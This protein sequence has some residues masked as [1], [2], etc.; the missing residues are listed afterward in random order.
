MSLFTIAL[1]G[2]PNCGKT[3]LFNNLTGAKAVGGIN[4]RMRDME[5][6]IPVH[7]KL[8]NSNFGEGPKLTA[9]KTTTPQRSTNTLPPPP[10]TASSMNTLR[11]W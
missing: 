10:E 3:T 1:I 4:D 7:T 8:A 6:A 9:L 5:R 2:N 11:N